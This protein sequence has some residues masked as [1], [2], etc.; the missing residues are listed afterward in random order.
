[1]KPATYTILSNTLIG[2]YCNES[3]KMMKA[4]TPRRN[5]VKNNINWFVLHEGQKKLFHKACLRKLNHFVS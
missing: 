3:L 5:I 2:L 1:M 4:E